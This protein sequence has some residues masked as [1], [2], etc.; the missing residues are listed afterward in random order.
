M[1]LFSKAGKTG[2][3]AVQNVPKIQF[4]ELARSLLYI[5]DAGARRMKEEKITE[6]GGTKMMTQAQKDK[7]KDDIRHFFSQ[8]DYT[9]KNDVIVQGQKCKY[10]VYDTLKR[11]R[12]AIRV[13]TYMQY[14]DEIEQAIAEAKEL[15]KKREEEK[16]K[17]AEELARYLREN[18]HV[19]LHDK[20]W[21]TGRRIYILSARLDRPDWEKIKHCMYYVNTY[22]DY[23]GEWNEEFRGWA[24]R[25]DK[26]EE[27]ENILNVKPELRLKA[28]EERAKKEKEEHEMKKKIRA[29][30]QK[31]IDEAFQ[32]AEYVQPTAGLIQVEGEIIDHPTCER[33]VY[34]TGI[35]FII[36]KDEGWIWKI[37][38]HGM[39]GDNW[40]CNNVATEGA[41]AIGV[42]VKYTHEL[43]HLIREFSEIK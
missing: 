22:N 34:G 9:V 15:K 25:E 40:R 2:K 37:E 18:I 27:L 39:D 23:H 17:R 1:R 5:Y 12:L 42:R 38:N 30:Y 11:C 7:M 19:V 26:I 6:K 4:L 36:Q 29:Q 10:A 31:K 32:N 8:S 43:E 20:D 3:K 41:G 16:K 14:K 28:R 33:D 21:E 13:E 35:W 24:V